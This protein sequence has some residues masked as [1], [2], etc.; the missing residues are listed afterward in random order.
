MTFDVFADENYLTNRHIG[1]NSV[2]HFKFTD[3]YGKGPQDIIRTSETKSSL[4]RNNSNDISLRA[5]YISGNFQFQI[6]WL[7]ALQIRR[8]TTCKTSYHIH[9]TY[10]Q[11]Q[12][13]SLTHLQG[14]GL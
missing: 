6:R 4:Y 11:C 8:T 3:L 5:Y 2:E 12:N 1:Q 13:P 7:I 14:I 10:C 9:Q